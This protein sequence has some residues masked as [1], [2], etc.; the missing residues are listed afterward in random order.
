[1]VGLCLAG[2]GEGWMVGLCLAGEGEGW[3][4]GLCLAGEGEG[5][6]RQKERRGR[7]TMVGFLFTK[8]RLRFFANRWRMCSI[9]YYFRNSSVSI[10]NV[11]NC[12]L[13]Y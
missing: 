1:M 8:F 10:N 3:M 4:V 13:R 2:E 7:D 12:K 9:S 6:I 5:W 11:T